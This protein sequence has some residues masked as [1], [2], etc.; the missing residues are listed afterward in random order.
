[1]K[2]IR[3]AVLGLE[4]K[5]E[6]PESI[7]EAVELYGEPIVLDQFIKNTLYRGCSSKARKGLVDKLVADY[8]EDVDLSPL[9]ETETDDEG[10]VT[11]KWADRVTEKKIVDFFKEEVGLTDA[12]LQ[13]ILDTVEVKFDPRTQERTPG[14]ASRKPGKT[15]LKAAQANIEQYGAATVAGKLKEKLEAMGWEFTVEEDEN[16]EPTVECIARGIKDFQQALK[17]QAMNE[18]GL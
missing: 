2:E 17:E 15:Y 13:G 18:I 3:Q 1:M 5:T 12:D 4:Y 9:E 10:N 14:G 11:T 16:G 7:S 6:V 8:G